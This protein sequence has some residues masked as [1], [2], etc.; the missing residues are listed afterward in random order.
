MKIIEKHYTTQ[1]TQQHN[2][3]Q[4]ITNNTYTYTHQH[5]TLH[6]QTKYTI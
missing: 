2:N 4:H 6:K 1:T 3:T 5:T